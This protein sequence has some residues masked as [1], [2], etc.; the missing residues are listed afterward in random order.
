MAQQAGKRKGAAAFVIGV[1]AEYPRSRL[2]LIVRLILTRLIK[3]RF[4]PYQDAIFV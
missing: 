1:H 2:Q 3:R 4:R